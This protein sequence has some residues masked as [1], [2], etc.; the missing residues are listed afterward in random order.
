MRW[1]RLCGPFPGDRW[2][3]L[4]LDRATALAVYVAGTTHQRFPPR[5]LADI[6][7]LLVVASPDGAADA[8]AFDAAAAVGAVKAGLGGRVTV[9]ARGVPGAVGPPT[10]GAMLTHLN[11][12][13]HTVL[14]VVAHGTFPR[15]LDDFCLVLEHGMEGKARP[16]SAHRVP[17]TTLIQELARV[18]LPYMTFLC[19]CESARPGAAAHDRFADR[20]ARKLALPAVIG[21]ADPVT[22]ETAGRIAQA[23]YTQ[24]LADGRPDVAL[25][26]ARVGRVQRH[27]VLVPVLVSQ[28]GSRP[29]FDPDLD[30]EPT[31]P[32]VIRRG[33]TRLRWHLRRRSPALNDRLQ[34]KY[35]DYRRRPPGPT[36][37]DWPAAR[38]ELNNW[39]DEA[40]GVSFNGLCNAAGPD[41]QDYHG[42]ACPF[43][44][45]RPIVFAERR[46]FKS[47]DEDAKR[48]AE[49]LRANG[50]LAVVGPSGSGKSSLVL[51]GV[52]QWLGV[53]ECGFVDFRPGGNAVAELATACERLRAADATLARAHPGNVRIRAVLVVDQFEE[54]FTHTSNDWTRDTFLARLREERELRKVVITL[55]S[56]FRNRL[57]DTWLWDLAEDA[58]QDIKPMS[59]ADLSRAAREQA[60][61][62]GMRFEANLVPQILGDMADE[63]GRMP[64]LQHTLRELWR[65]RRGVWLRTDEYRE[66]GGIHGA[67]TQTADGLVNGLGEARRKRVTDLFLRLTRLADE[68]DVANKTRRRVRIVDL[69]PAGEAEGPTRA[70]LTRLVDEYLVVTSGEE[71]E[72]AHEALIRPWETLGEWVSQHRSNA[73]VRQSVAVAALTWTK[74]GRRTDDLVHRGQ[75]LAAGEQIQVDEV[76]NINQTERDCLMSCRR[77][78][79]YQRRFRKAISCAFVLLLCAGYF[80]LDQQAKTEKERADERGNEAAKQE[81]LR[82]LAEENEKEATRLGRVALIR[83]LA[84]R[85]LVASNNDQDEHAVQL[86]A[87]AY[88][89]TQGITAPVEGEVD[90]ALRTV[91]SKDYWCY[92]LFAP[93]ARWAVALSKE[94][95]L[96][97]AGGFDHL[98][99]SATVHIWSVAGQPTHRGTLKGPGI[100]SVFGLAFSP[101]GKSLAAACGSSGLQ[102]WSID[103]VRTK[104]VAYIGHKKGLRSVRFS[105]DGKYIAASGHDDAVHIWQVGKST[106]PYADLKLPDNNGESRIAFSPDGNYLAASSLSANIRRWLLIRN[107]AGGTMK[108]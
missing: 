73:L 69:V 108:S 92:K 67:V 91:L 95:Q 27:D 6:Q 9:L 102:I 38:D 30:V 31:D 8:P 74:S 21:M 75:Q 78:Q 77:S 55:R 14:H 61:E 23:F 39:A 59:A 76:L 12:G 94:N 64:L 1:E 35:P 99:N 80:T 87:L 13:R 86:A 28:L 90:H 56:E 17:G 20:L 103:T 46:F 88:K 52:M 42:D 62:V 11:R 106:R 71:A 15:D 3:F 101:D 81:K 104:P 2:D 84:S 85:A 26:A 16:G 5:G 37:A 4:A 47:R 29:L 49:R 40:L 82:V 32:L 57:K 53:G 45:M 19:A 72:V 83:A 34:A 100:D 24:L 7:V 10:L 54:L 58:G 25:A 66:L 98:G 68:S 89:F 48:L 96:L 97:A 33:L 79:W 107:R 105:T 44:G 41:P 51:A 36:T 60:N 50:A 65:R 93:E 43:S 70:L 63:P 18:R 22:Q